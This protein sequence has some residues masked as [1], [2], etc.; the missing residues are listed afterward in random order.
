MTTSLLPTAPRTGPSLQPR[1][2]RRSGALKRF[3]TA[4]MRSLAVAHV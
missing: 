2:V 4:L 1:P 3:L